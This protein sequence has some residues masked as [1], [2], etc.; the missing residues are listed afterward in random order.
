MNCRVCRHTFLTQRYLAGFADHDDGASFREQLMLEAAWAV[1]C[2]G[3]K[4]GT[5][6]RRLLIDWAT[7]RRWV[8]VVEDGLQPR[9]VCG[10]MDAEQLEAARRRR[11]TFVS[12]WD[13]YVARGLP[14]AV[15]AQ[16]G[17]MLFF[18]GQ[19]RSLESA[20]LAELRRIALDNLADKSV[21]N[22]VLWT[23]VDSVRAT[24]ETQA[25]LEQRREEDR[26][27]AGSWEV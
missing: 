15:R 24:L 22:T 2:G 25:I 12:P 16:V 19:L 1:R 20:K 9:S 7:C 26:Q 4:V 18:A 23:L 27:R 14:W 6:A 10:E 11:R 3:E 21:I 5:V 17:E 8:Q 13:R